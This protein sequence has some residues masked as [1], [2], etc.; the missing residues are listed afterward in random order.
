MIGTPY[1]DGS[2]GSYRISGMDNFYGDLA[3]AQYVVNQ[4]KEKENDSNW[5]VYGLV[6]IDLE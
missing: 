1:E 3:T 4:V 5:F 6:K 2:I